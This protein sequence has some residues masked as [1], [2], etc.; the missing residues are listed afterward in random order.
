MS[1]ISTGTTLTTGLVLTS[2]TNGELIIKTGASAVTAAT[3]SS[4]GTATLSN[5]AI[6]SL[7]VSSPS[8]FPAGSASAPAVTTT[9]DT[10]TGIY[11]PAAN[12]VAVTTGGTVATAFNSN[13][14]FFRNRIINGDMR[15]DQR[16]AGG[17][18]TV[19]V[20]ANTY[21]LDRWFSSGQTSD[22][23]FTI[24]RT[25]VAPTGFVNSAKI[26]VTTTDTSLGAT[27]FYIFRQAIEGTN[28]SDFNFGTAN[29]LTVTL[30]F[31]T[32]S[33][34][35][36]TFGGVLQN[37]GNDRNYPFTYTI[38]A[39]N[40]WEYKTITI[41][42]DTTG[43]WLTNNSRGMTVTFSLGAGTSASAT[44]NV[45][46]G[47]AYV[48]SVTGATNLMATLNANLY[49]TGVQL[50]SGSVATPFERRPFGTELSLCQRYYE[51]SYDLETA[52]GSSTEAGSFILVSPGNINRVFGQVVFKQFKRATPTMTF[53]ST[54][55]ASGNFRD[56][57]SGANCAASA[58]TNAGQSGIAVLSSAGISA[59]TD[60]VVGHFVAVSEL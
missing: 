60:T 22:G 5:V 55:G 50:E 37:D 54:T 38:N 40:T 58:A 14:L 28:V 24:E 25:T 1:I 19:N 53:Y 20:A 43:T 32:R 52:P 48:F 9:G 10:D 16:S 11:F 29:A 56:L 33:S 46:N 41:P 12:Q 45:W 21:S 30:S 13:G 4:G 49:F 51:K 8:V 42:G 7:T 57:T 36:G 47:T 44:A 3:F 15:I 34:L 2:D 31:W 27:Q 18:V 6:T 23:A 39:A 35:T 17:V 59:A 26:T